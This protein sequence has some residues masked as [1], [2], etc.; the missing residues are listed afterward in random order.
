MK[1]SASFIFCLFFAL[2]LSA[3]ENSPWGIVSDAVTQKP[4]AF[5]TISIVETRAGTVSDIDG[6]FSFKNIPVSGKMQI[7]YIGYKPQEVL[8]QN[9][10]WPLM[11]YLEPAG[12]ELETVVVTSGENP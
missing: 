6:H 12:K 3:Q 8:V 7:S 11:I 2:S 4:L 1:K 9:I 10:S 5:V